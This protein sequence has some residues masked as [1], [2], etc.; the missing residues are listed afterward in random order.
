MALSRFVA[1]NSRAVLTAKGVTAKSS[2]SLTNED[3]LYKNPLPNWVH[4]TDPSDRYFAIA[5]VIKTEG[6]DK[7][8]KYMTVTTRPGNQYRMRPGRNRF[9]NRDGINDPRAAEPQS[10]LEILMV[11]F[12]WACL[13][14]G[15]WEMHEYTRDEEVFPFRPES[16]KERLEEM[17]VKYAGSIMPA[18]SDTNKFNAWVEDHIKN[19]MD[20]KIPGC[21]QPV[22]GH[23]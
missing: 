17:E 15:F 20:E 21:L 14:R 4:S 22:H 3:D 23:H 13:M 10:P 2:P 19:N 18:V 9:I 16:V 1:R 6:T 5:N 8:S 11:S 7:D 12:G